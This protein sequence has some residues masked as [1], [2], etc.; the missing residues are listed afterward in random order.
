VKRCLRNLI[1]TNLTRQLKLPKD[2]KKFKAY[3]SLSSL[4]EGVMNYRKS[5]IDKMKE[6]N[7]LSV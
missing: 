3:Q 2:T 5:Y 4:N 7:K 6:P 1:D